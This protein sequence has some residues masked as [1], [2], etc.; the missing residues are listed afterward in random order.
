MGAS[1]TWSRLLLMLCVGVGACG[2]KTAHGGAE[3]GAGGPAQ[4]VTEGGT[5]GVAGAAGGAESAAG[6]AES[7]AGGAESAAGGAE[8]AAGA[9]GTV[10][11]SET[12]CSTPV[13]IDP[14]SPVDDCVVVPRSIDPESTCGTGDCAIVRAFDLSCEARIYDPR[15]SCL[16]ERT[17][18]LVAGGTYGTENR[19]L[20]VTDTETEVSQIGRLDGAMYRLSS[21]FETTWYVARDDTGIV[22]VSANGETWSKSSVVLDPSPGWPQ[23]HDVAM[24]D[25]A[26]G[27]VA[28]QTAHTGIPHLV[29]RDGSCWTDEVLTDTATEHLRL[30]VDAEGL[31]WTAWT[32]QDAEGQ[33]RIVLRDPWGMTQPVYAATQSW[34]DGSAQSV[35]MLPGGFDGH[36]PDPALAFLVDDGINVARRDSG[37]E[38][39]WSVVV[40]PDS[41]PGSTETDCLY[42]DSVDPHPCEGLTSCTTQIE[43]NGER[44]G[45]ARTASQGTFAVWVSYS[46]LGES[47]LIESDDGGELPQF[48]CRPT[49]TTGSGTAELVLARLGDAAPVF[50]RY[51]FDLDAGL[52]NLWQPVAVAARGDTLI[53]TAVVSGGDD[54]ALTYFEIDSTLLP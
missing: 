42:T 30:G 18:L 53:V 49:E 8:S 4:S 44:Y 33:T 36:D 48:L 39:G 34:R 31:P 23:V 1:E 10:S 40:L 11:V 27:Y 12:L 7:A 28:Y 43:G 14:P 54:P 38:T 52:L 26:L 19:L 9:A 22:A 21:A 25:E 46:S 2:G 6:G 47:T 32:E 29:T 45:W 20:T 16:D 17:L 35:T 41:S 13:T 37:S 3:T 51:R 50:T 5:S 24:V 15:L